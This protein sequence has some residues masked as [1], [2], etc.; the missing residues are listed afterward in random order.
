MKVYTASKLSDGPL[1]RRI[2][3]EWSE[4]EIVA[5][6]P[7]SHVT[8]TGAPD[9]PEDCAAHGAVFWQHDHEDVVRSDVVLVYTDSDEP[10][11]GALIEVGMAIALAKMIIVVGRH[12]S[13]STWWYHPQ[14]RRVASLDE[15]RSL[16]RLMA[17]A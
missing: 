15:A 5:R 2:A 16:L 7:F 3:T 6:W 1:W 13:Y 14:V 4:I 11:K 12:R 17:I 8:D 9:W 10:L